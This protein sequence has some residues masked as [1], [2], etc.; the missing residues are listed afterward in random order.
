M[1]DLLK[2]VKNLNRISRIYIKIGNVIVFTVFVLA[3]F[4]SFSMGRI[5]NYDYLLF[6]KAELL[7]LGKEM[8][9]AIYVPALLVE[10]FSLAEK[11][12]I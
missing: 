1:Q 5:G 9:G 3:A 10:I 8:I 6:L 11:Y 2:C 12:S 4:C 7:V